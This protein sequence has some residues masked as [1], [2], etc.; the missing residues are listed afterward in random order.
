M[1]P[2]LSKASYSYSVFVTQRCQF[3]QPVTEY[4]PTGTSTLADAQPCNRFLAG[5]YGN[6][7]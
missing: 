1:Q 5:W 2:M 4:L 7:V 6:V 3:I